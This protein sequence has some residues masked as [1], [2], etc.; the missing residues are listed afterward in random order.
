MLAPIS[1]PVPPDGYGPWEKVVWNLTEELVHR[2]IAGMASAGGLDA[3]DGEIERYQQFAAG[4]LTELSIR[5]FDNPMEGL[6][7]LGGQA[8]TDKIHYCFGS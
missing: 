4:G 3:I 6:K 5:L 7:L 2:L 8:V 1:W